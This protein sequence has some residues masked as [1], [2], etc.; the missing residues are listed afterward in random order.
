[1]RDLEE[2]YLDDLN[3]SKN[4]DDKVDIH[5]KDNDDKHDDDDSDDDHTKDVRNLS[6][7]TEQPDSR[8]D[9]TDDQKNVTDV[10]NS[11]D[12]DDIGRRKRDTEQDEFDLDEVLD[13]LEVMLWN[14]WK[15]VSSL[16]KTYLTVFCVEYVVKTSRPFQTRNWHRKTII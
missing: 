7:T 10:N 3:N 1:M 13:R 12:N 5:D 2:E 14:F 15:I 9:D 11:Q 4:D 16:V 6:T 8:Q